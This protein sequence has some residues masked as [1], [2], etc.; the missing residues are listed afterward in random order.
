MSLPWGGSAPAG[1]FQARKR[2]PPLPGKHT[3]AVKKGG[4][5]HSDETQSLKSQSD[6][7]TFFLAARLRSHKEAPSFIGVE[8]FTYVSHS[9]SIN[10]HHPTLCGLTRMVFRTL[11]QSS[12]AAQPLET[13]AHTTSACTHCTD[14]LQD[15]VPRCLLAAHDHRGC[16]AAG[17]ERFCKGLL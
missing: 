14:G 15:L 12:D 10:W 9:Y 16:R 17:R 13:S 11:A 7:L 4:G 8:L 2:L 1:S 3:P 6:E 5:F